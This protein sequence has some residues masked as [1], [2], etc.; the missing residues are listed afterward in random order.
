M[1]VKILKNDLQFDLEP[2][3]LDWKGIEESQYDSDSLLD[4]IVGRNKRLVPVTFN[5]VGIYQT[6]RGCWYE[7]KLPSGR[8]VAVECERDYFNRHLSE[9]V[10]EEQALTEEEWKMMLHL[11]E[12]KIIPA[13][14][15]YKRESWRRTTL[16][17]KR[18]M[19]KS[20][21][22]RRSNYECS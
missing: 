10:G 7:F 12:R 13:C 8:F 21:M 14:D 18:D 19:N 15:R 1:K 20:L 17:M 6:T 16:R 4:R 22:R 3:W 2:F 5:R 11:V 9:A